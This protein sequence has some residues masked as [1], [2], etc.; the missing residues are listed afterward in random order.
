MLKL[1]YK[2]IA[3]AHSFFGFGHQLSIPH[4]ECHLWTIVTMMIQ[5]VSAITF[6]SVILGF[7]LDHGGHVQFTCRRCM[8][9]MHAFRTL[10]ATVL[11]CISLRAKSFRCVCADPIGA[12]HCVLCTHACLRYGTQISGSRIGCFSRSSF[13]SGNHH[14]CSNTVNVQRY[15]LRLCALNNCHRGNIGTT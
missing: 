11:R 9:C 4:I 1:C 10:A 13:R 12:L 3:V 5:S 14:R 7:I 6:Q 2:H 15:R 8:R